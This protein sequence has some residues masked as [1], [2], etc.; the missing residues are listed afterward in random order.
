MKKMSML[1]VCLVMAAAM[2]ACSANPGSV[3]PSESPS[4]YMSP[5][6]TPASQAL[7]E[8][9]AAP[10]DDAAMTATMTGPQSAELSRKAN[11]AAAKISE[12]DSCVTAI[13]GDTCVAGVTF[14]A[15]YQG[16]LTDRIRDM[17]ASCIQSAVPVVE[18]VAVTADPAIA[19]QINQMAEKIS[20]AAALAPL[21]EEFDGV[22]NS[23]Q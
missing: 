8:I 21:T 20:G 17:V 16:A 14:D 7:D 2:T 23:I 3:A 1:L 6:Q 18:R 11:E 5:T 12:I 22:L 4:A 9:G 15:Q 13:L 10:T 19:A